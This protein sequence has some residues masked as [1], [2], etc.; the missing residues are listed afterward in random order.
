MDVNVHNEYSMFKDYQQI[1]ISKDRT[2]YSFMTFLFYFYL[3]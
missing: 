3:Y 1:K 2:N